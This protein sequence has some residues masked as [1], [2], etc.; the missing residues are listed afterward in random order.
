MAFHQKGKTARA[1][2]REES[3]F[4]EQ[5]S[6]CKN[7]GD[8][9][10]GPVEATEAGGEEAEREHVELAG[11][12]NASKTRRMV[13]KRRLLVCEQDVVIAEKIEARRAPKGP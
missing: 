3:A 8:A 7:S 2:V 4:R 13:R 12:A 1:S 6:D 11:G 5:A 9:G 10:L